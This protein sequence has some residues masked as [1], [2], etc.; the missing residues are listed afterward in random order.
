[1]GYSTSEKELKKLYSDEEDNDPE[2]HDAESEEESK[3]PKY[4]FDDLESILLWVKGDDS[5]NEGDN[6]KV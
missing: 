1:M 4:S 6:R 3:Q 5:S 2:E